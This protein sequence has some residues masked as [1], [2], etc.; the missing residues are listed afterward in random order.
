MSGRWWVVPIE[1]LEVRY[2][3]QW[4]RWF[5]EVLQGM[6]IEA[7]FIDAP[8]MPAVAHPMQ[9]EQILGLQPSDDIVVGDF[10]DAYG[11]HFYKAQQ[12]ATL[13]QLLA[14]QCIRDD[15]VVFFLDAWHPGITALAYMRDLGRVAF[16]LGGFFH[17][18]SWD[19]H[20][21]LSRVNMQR[22]CLGVERG[23]LQAMDCACVATQYHADMLLAAR[24]Q[25][26]Q[27]ADLQPNVVVTGLPVYPEFSWRA[28]RWEQRPR[29]VVFPHR[30]HPDK[31]LKAAERVVA[32]ARELN[33]GQPIEFVRTR[34]EYRTKAEYYDLLGSSRV[35]LSTA[36]AENF[37]IGMVEAALLGCWPVA[38]RRLSY[39]ETLRED[40]LYDTEQQAAQALL[41]GLERRM[42]FHYPADRWTQAIPNMVQAM[43]EAP[44]R[45][46]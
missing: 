3:K 38:P 19:R 25:P 17:A 22:W 35:V 15:D 31:G 34:D 42:P 28:Q 40:R 30:L 24:G 11:T 44:M 2:T 4:R 18:G 14:R 26:V 39:P 13:A 37:G 43:Y 27:V 20:D 21:L 29:R 9:H 41:R 33:R 16:K 10:L 32:L 45:G 23:W 6:G 7:F 36:L 12:V 5:A 46:S 8:T 1:P